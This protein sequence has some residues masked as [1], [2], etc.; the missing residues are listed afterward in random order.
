MKSLASI[1]LPKLFGPKLVSISVLSVKL[2]SSVVAFPRASLKLTHR[3]SLTRPSIASF[4]V[5]IQSHKIQLLYK[6][7]NM[8]RSL[9]KQLSLNIINI[10]IY[11]YIN[12]RATLKNDEWC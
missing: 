1:L 9:E 8:N 7:C 10:I 6:K 11:S 2:A 4:Y 5:I 3:N 12:Q